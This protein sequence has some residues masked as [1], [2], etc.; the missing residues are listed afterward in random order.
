[1]TRTDLAVLTPVQQWRAPRRTRRLT[2][3]MVG[4]ILFGVSMAMMIRAGL[5]L[6]PWDVLHSG[7]AERTGLSFGT[8]VIG[9]SVLVLALWVPLRQQPG[10]GTVANAIVVGVSADAALAVMAA[11]SAVSGR[12]LVLAAAVALNALAGALYIGAQFGPGPRDGLMT[13]LV[14]RTSLSVRLVRT[15]L[16]VTVLVTGLALGGTAGVGTLVYA[17]GIGPLVHVLLP[18]CTVDIADPGP[19]GDDIAPR[20]EAARPAPHSAM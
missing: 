16:E 2:Q 14:R 18:W 13:G 8:V 11:P 12:V 10:L 19:G 20:S 6:A 1:M 4:L 17:L 3:L 5:G 15:G 7:L 9:A